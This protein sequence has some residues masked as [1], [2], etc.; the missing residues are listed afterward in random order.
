LWRQN[1]RRLEAEA[2]RDAMLSASGRLS[3]AMGGR[4]VFPELSAEVLSTQSKPGSGWDK[5]SDAEQGRRSVY[6]FVKR[7]LGVPFMETFD[8]PT[9][10]K[11]CPARTTTTIAPQALVLLNSSF[12]DQQAAA[13][14]ERLIRETGP[15]LAA[16]VDRAFRLALSRPPSADE[17]A[18][19]QAFLDRQSAE[20]TKLA[21]GSSQADL[22]QVAADRQSLA[23]FC[24]L[25][26]NLNEFVYVD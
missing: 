17:A 5:S 7:T 18:V 2:I 20:W 11:P 10:D 19:A 24:K 12:T 23:A 8:A 16:Q 15:D 25:V 1:L 6:I 26:F 22:S 4:G 9:P 21:A 3:L 13:M 14:A